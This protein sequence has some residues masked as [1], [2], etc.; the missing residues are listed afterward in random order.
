MCMHPQTPEYKN[1][2]KYTLI[3]LQFTQILKGYIIMKNQYC[4]NQENH[5]YKSHM[6]KSSVL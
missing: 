6:T 5:G 3:Q 1:K 2:N 4:Q